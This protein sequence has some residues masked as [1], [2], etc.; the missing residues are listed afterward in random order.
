MA[1]PGEIILVSAVKGRGIHP[2]LNEGM[3]GK[4]KNPRHELIFQRD[5]DKNSLRTIAGPVAC[6]RVLSQNETSW[7]MP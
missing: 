5:R 3:E 4:L 7:V 6:H 2:G 1:E